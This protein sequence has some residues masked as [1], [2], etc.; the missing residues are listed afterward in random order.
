VEVLGVTKL[1][2]GWPLFLLGAWL[3]YLVI[4]PAMPRLR[5]AHE[6]ARRQGQTASSA[7]SDDS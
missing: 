1:V 6:A 7:S 5:A 2:M 4:R 3:N